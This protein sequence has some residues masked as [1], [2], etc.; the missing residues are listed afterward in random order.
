MALLGV[1]IQGNYD[2]ALA[3]AS[4]WLSFS[5]RGGTGLDT[6]HCTVL[7]H[8]PSSLRHGALRCRFQ[9]A[10]KPA[11]PSKARLRV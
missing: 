10:T 9:Q 6:T 4:L 11:C 3:R 5:D 8:L 7:L 1:H 2:I